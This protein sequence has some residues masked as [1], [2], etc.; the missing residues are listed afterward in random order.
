MQRAVRRFI[1]WRHRR[2]G[3]ESLRHMPDYLLRDIGISR[4]QVDHFK[5]REH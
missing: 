2:Q 1:R 5:E 3:S 4:F